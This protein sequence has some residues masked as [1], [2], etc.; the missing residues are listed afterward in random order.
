MSGFEYKDL[1]E[2]PDDVA[3][4]IMTVADADS[5]FELDVDEVNDFLNGMDDFYINVEKDRFFEE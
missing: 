1:T 3:D 4:Y 5:L 2:V